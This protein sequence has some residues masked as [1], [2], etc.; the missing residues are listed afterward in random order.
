M[1]KR[2]WL[3][4]RTGFAFLTLV[5]VM[6]TGVMAEDHH[7]RRNKI[8]GVW[9]SQVSILNCA[10][11]ATLA[12]FRGLQKYELGGTAQVVPATNPTALSAH[13]GIWSHVHGNNYKL[14]FKMFR[15]DPAGNNI[16]W[17][18]VRFDIALNED[19]SAYAGVGHADVIDSNGN[20]IGASCP[21]L[22]G[23]RFE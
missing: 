7:A 14:A 1:N 17:Q 22:T 15:F 2:L 10:T 4:L 3:M 6:Q 20:L 13:V 18:I 12:S 11:G 5:V 9:D 19:A 16:G 23:T 8:V 21:T